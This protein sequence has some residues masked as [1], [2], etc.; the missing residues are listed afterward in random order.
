MKKMCIFFASLLVLLGALSGCGIFYDEDNPLSG[1]NTDERI[2]MALEKA[3][4]GHDFK[5]VKEYGKHGGKYYAVCADENGLEFRVRNIIY[6]NAYH[7]GC[8]DEYMQE[9]LERQSYVEKATEIAEG[10]GYR[11]K[12]DKVNG[13]VSLI[14]YVASPDDSVDVND[15]AQ[16]L[17]DILNSVETPKLVIGDET[18]STGEINY[19]T[20]SYMRN[21]TYEFFSHDDDMLSIGSVTFEEKDCNIEELLPDIQAEL[22]WAYESLAA[23]QAS[24]GENGEMQ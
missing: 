16:T 20:E 22:N 17:K 12:Y 8:H 14:I 13:F 9:V 3:Y 7:F 15:I 10:R 2:I 5:T 4:P 24:T 11:L 19:Y 18:F 21:I 23:R 6:D 1:K